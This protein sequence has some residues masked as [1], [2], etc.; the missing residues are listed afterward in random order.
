[1]SQPGEEEMRVDPSRAKV[2]LENIEQVV[3]R[4]DAVKG[5]RN[6]RPQQ[7]HKMLY[8]AGADGHLR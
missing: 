5:S 4:V 3:K 8:L 6:V 2:L 1:M 7:Q